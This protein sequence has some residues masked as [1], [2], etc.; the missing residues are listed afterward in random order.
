M[1]ERFKIFVSIRKEEYSEVEFKKLILIIDC[2][3]AVLI[4]SRYHYFPV[5]KA[6][7]EGIL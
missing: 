4:Y 1:E 3:L 5:E 7:R 2:R 6:D